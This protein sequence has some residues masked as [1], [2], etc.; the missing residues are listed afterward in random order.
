MPKEKKL[1]DKIRLPEKIPLIGR[2]NMETYE[3]I[4]KYNTLPVNDPK[5]KE[6][7]EKIKDNTEYEQ[8]WD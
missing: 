8:Y 7:Y 4:L 5:R 1:P 2:T 6:I 3:L